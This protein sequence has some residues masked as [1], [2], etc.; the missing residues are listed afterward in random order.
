[1]DGW[2]QSGGVQP[3]VDKRRHDLSDGYAIIGVRSK[4]RPLQK[5]STDSI[6]VRNDSGSAYLEIKGDDMTLVGSKLRMAFDTIDA[7]ST[8]FTKNNQ[9]DITNTQGYSVNATGYSEMTGSGVISIGSNRNTRIDGE[10]YVDHKH[11][12]VESGP[13][14]TGGVVG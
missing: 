2:W 6:Q 7:E 9:L 13:S 12:N 5:Y 11:S 3:E 4:A 1:M 8:T 14:N 10:V